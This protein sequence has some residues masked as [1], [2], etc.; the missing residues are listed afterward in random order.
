MQEQI[1]GVLAG[2][3]AER[4]RN[5]VDTLRRAELLPGWYDD[6][7]LPEQARLTHVRLRALQIIA[8]SFLATHDYE[9]ALERQKRRWKSNRYMKVLWRS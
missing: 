1:Q 9:L 7:V 3:P 8:R 5:S 2:R 4:S 6:W